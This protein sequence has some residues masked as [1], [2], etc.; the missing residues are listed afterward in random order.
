MKA[1]GIILAGGSSERLGKLTAERA[2]AAMPVCGCYRSL[3]FTLSNMSNSGVNKVAVITQY[4]PRSL[5]DHLSSSKWWDLG[6]KQGGLFVFSPYL[7][8]S[9]SMWYQGT[10]DSIYKNISFLLRSNEPYVII[11]SGD[12]IYKM[13]YNDLIA[14]HERTKADITLVYRK[15]DEGNLQD[16][17]VL[18]FDENGR[19]LDFEEK[20]LDPQSDNISMGIYIIHR[21]LLIKLLEST[22]AE[23]RYD[24]VK[25]IIIRYRRK[26]NIMGYRYDGYW[27]AINSVKAYYDINMDFLD[28][29]LRY[30]F[31][32]RYPYVESKPKDEPPAKFNLHAKAANSI[33]GSGC[34]I[35]GVVRDSVLF[36]KVFTGENSRIHNSVVMEGC[37]IGNNCVVEHAILD[38]EVVLSDGQ[39]IVGEPD[40]PVIIAKG[41]VI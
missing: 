25:D 3:D 34:I 5:Q 7:S 35:N 14:A 28:R 15:H 17:G 24:L 6:R 18:E 32:M 20:P 21:T 22:A 4:N 8:D 9:N 19:L 38:K 13:N 41:S 12:S 11:G 26:L 10:A 23:G 40:D 36:R 2:V 16:Y 30:S 27:R 31:T 37:F 29:D 33:M 1:L 39:S